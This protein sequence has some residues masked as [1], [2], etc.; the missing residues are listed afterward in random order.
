MKLAIHF[1]QIMISEK[2]D[3]S[4][5]KIQQCSSNE[6]IVIVKQF[7]GCDIDTIVLTKKDI[8]RI[9]MHINPCLAKEVA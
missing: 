8:D 5:T 9:S 6:D 2:D 7:D 1:D 3:G 4:W